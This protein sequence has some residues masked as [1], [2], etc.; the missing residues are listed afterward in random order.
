MGQWWRFLSA[1]FVHLSWQHLGMNALGLVLI[2]ALFP[3]VIPWN[4]WVVVLLLCSLSVTFGIWLFHP[5]IVWYVGFSGALHGILV[6]LLVLDYLAKQ[7]RLNILLFIAV[8]AKLLW[9]IFMGPIPGSESTA[10]GPVVVQA[11]FYGF[12]GGLLM[13][14]FLFI[15]NKYKNLLV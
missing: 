11:H 5:N 10:G 6:L 4:A 15:S 3:N 13:F 1:N 2:Y 14:I 9:E 8:L 7:H 12:I